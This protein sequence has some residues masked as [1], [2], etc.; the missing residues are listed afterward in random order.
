[1]HLNLASDEGVWSASSSVVLFAVENPGYAPVSVWRQWRLD[2]SSSYWES[3]PGC[4]AP[5]SHLTNWAIKS[6]LVSERVVLILHQVGRAE[7]MELT[8]QWPGNL[9]EKR[10]LERTRCRWGHNTKM[11]LR[12]IL[13]E[14]VDWIQLARDRVKWRPSS[15]RVITLRVS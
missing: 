14:G 4:P 1:M 15:N 12:W 2:K 13:C 9:K 11:Y 5:V 6:Y 7:Y 10:L 3:I 8:K